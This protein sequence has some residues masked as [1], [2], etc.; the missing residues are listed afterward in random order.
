M[1]KKEGGGAE[2]RP[3]RGPCRQEGDAE[4]QEVAVAGAR[5]VERFV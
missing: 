2:E 1:N 4:W 5:G 3:A